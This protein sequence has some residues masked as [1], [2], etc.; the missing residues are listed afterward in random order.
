MDLP[1]GNISLIEWNIYLKSG[2]TNST[3]KEPLY[4][5]EMVERLIVFRMDRLEG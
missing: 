2:A 1:T 3:S 4:K 5:S